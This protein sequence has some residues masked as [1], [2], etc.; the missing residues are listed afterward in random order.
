MNRR[1]AQGGGA[2]PFARAHRTASESRPTHCDMASRESSARA[3]QQVH[4]MIAG[5]ATAGSRAGVPGPAAAVDLTGCDAGQ[6]DAR[7][8]GAPD[9]PVAVPDATGVQVKAVPEATMEARKGS[10]VMLGKSGDR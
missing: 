7:T 10:I 2:A 9:R 5:N 8:L 3:I 4:E 1:A 6:A